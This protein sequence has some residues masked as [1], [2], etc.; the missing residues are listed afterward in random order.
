[1]AVLAALPH[2]LHMQRRPCPLSRLAHLAKISLQRLRVGLSARRG[3]RGWPPPHLAQSVGFRSSRLASQWGLA[4]VTE[5]AAELLR[6]LALG[7]L[8]RTQICLVRILLPPLSHPPLPRCLEAKGSTCASVKARGESMRIRVAAFRRRLAQK[9]Q[10]MFLRLYRKLAHPWPLQ[11][12]PPPTRPRL[13]P[14]PPPPTRPHARPRP[15]AQHRQVWQPT[16]QR[17]KTRLVSQDRRVLR[18][19][20]H[21]LKGRFLIRRR[22]PPPS[23]GMHV[24]RPR[25]RIACA[26]RWRRSRLAS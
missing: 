13:P 23:L 1:M 6:S 19:P 9:A 5:V 21:S 17:Q 7:G 8:T 15:P 25:F 18:L 26:A 3:W 14:P 24:Q 11:R 4:R 12:P 20:R 16:R 10:L 2:A 22:Q